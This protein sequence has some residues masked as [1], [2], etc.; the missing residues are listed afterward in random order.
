[1]KNYFST[2]K[3][4]ILSVGIFYLM[5]K[6]PF[7]SFIFFILPK[8]KRSG[9]ENIFRFELIIFK[10]IECFLKTINGFIEVPIVFLGV[11]N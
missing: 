10:M 9:L 3:L 2:T 5:T 8:K 4:V 1:M 7:R 6:I 11:F